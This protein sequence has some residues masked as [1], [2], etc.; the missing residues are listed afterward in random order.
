MKL[1]CRVWALRFGREIEKLRFYNTVTRSF[2]YQRR[3][4]FGQ[5]PNQK[6]CVWG[7]PEHRKREGRGAC[8]EW[9]G[10]WGGEGCLLPSRL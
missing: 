2:C 3:R 4:Q 9:S 1:R 6:L 5:W 7:R 8:T 10:V